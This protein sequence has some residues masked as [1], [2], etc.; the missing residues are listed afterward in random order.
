MLSSTH[1]LSNDSQ[2]HIVNI[3]LAVFLHIGN[4][5]SHNMHSLIDGCCVY[6]VHCAPL[7]SYQMFHVCLLRDHVHYIS[8]NM[9]NQ[10]TFS[11]TDLF[12]LK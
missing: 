8:K 4:R 12:D 5:P 10:R 6:D 7:N 9:R 1:C 2:V 3:D 11:S